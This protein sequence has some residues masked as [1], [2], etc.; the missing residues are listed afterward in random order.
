MLGTEASAACQIEGSLRRCWNLHAVFPHFCI[1]ST[2]APEDHMSLTDIV[3]VAHRFLTRFLS[4]SANPHPSTKYTFQI[5]RYT[6]YSSFLISEYFQ[7]SLFILVLVLIS[8][9][10]Q[11]IQ[12]LPT[13]RQPGLLN[14]WSIVLISR[15]RKPRAQY[16][17]SL[18][19][20]I[21]CVMDG[22]RV[23]L[24]EVAAQLMRHQPSTDPEA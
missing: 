11:I 10:L 13:L 1:S 7:S 20:R 24:G 2:T 8:F 19:S 6:R 3:R 14:A 5:Y 22:D 4:N 23:E 16:R 9:N 21:R 15:V 12:H 18:A 17:R